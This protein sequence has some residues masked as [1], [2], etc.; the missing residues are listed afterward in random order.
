MN[1]DEGSQASQAKVCQSHTTFHRRV[2]AHHAHRHAKTAGG[3]Y[4]RCTTTR[5]RRLYVTRTT[6]F[7]EP[8]IPHLPCEAVRLG[9]QPAHVTHFRVDDIHT[10]LSH[11][12]LSH[13][14]AGLPG[15]L[16]RNAVQEGPPALVLFLG[17]V[18]GGVPGG[19]DRA[20]EVHAAAVSAHLRHHPARDWSREVGGGGDT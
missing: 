15:E 20:L 8:P 18:V 7:T 19:D 13:A 5:G 11:F 2:K 4:V 16:L 3:E 10:A 1:Q 9:V 6:G 12:V 14:V 17:G